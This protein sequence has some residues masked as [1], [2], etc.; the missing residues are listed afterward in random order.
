VSSWN[1]VVTGGAKGIGFA[2]SEDLVSRGFNVVITGRDSAALDAAVQR[3]KE[4]NP[5]VSVTG[6]VMDVQDLDSITTTFSEIGEQFE[7]LAA[8]VNCA[9]IVI[10]EDM[11]TVSDDTWLTVINTN[12]TG[13]F[14]C[15]KAALPLLK[16]A[17]AGAS[18]VNI[19]SIAGT[20]GIAGRTS[21]TASKAGLEGLTRT[22]ALELAEFGIRVNGVAPGWTRTEMV[23]RGIKEGKINHDQVSSRI[24]LKRFAEPMEIATVVNFLNSDEASYITGQ[25]I[26]VDGGITI[27]G[28]T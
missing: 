15:S 10:R 6:K 13:A 14:R 17:P 1:A 25:T 16:S 3:L 20:L 22:M 27:N 23:D 8:L 24:A 26:V 18:I 19:S 21:Y 28:N 7:S 5:E 9:G 4:S 12:L 2:I 11:E